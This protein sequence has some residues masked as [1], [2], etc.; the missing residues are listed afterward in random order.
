MHQMK[1]SSIAFDVPIREELIAAELE[2]NRVPLPKMTPEEHIRDALAHP[3]GTG[4]LDTVVEAGETV[5]VVIP[6]TTRK[7]Q[8][9]AIYVPILVEELNACGVRDED[10]LI[11]SA[12]G[13]H[14]R[15]TRE[16]WA[17]LVGEEILG[18]VRCEDHVCTDDANLK[19]MGVTS[20]GTPVWLNA[21]AMA[22]DKLI[23][24]GGA[25]YHFLA[26]YGGGRK[27]VLPGIAGRETI[28]KNHNLALNEGFGSGSNPMVRSANLTG[29]NPFHA[30]MAEAAELAKPCFLLNVVADGDFNIIRAFAGDYIEAHAAACKLVDD[31]DGVYVEERTPLVIAS[32]GGYP[33]DIN[34]YQTSKTL[35]NA[36]AVVADG[37]T[38]IL[39]SECRE[40]FGDADCAR[41]I[42]GFDNMLDRERDLRENFSIGAYVGFLFCESA[43]RYRFIM[44]TDIPKEKF[45]NTKIHAVK[46][47]G[48]A[49]AL[50]K[51]LN[52]GSL[53]LRTT[54]LP[55]GANT[56][57]KFRD[58][59]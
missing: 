9:P 24:T 12:T 35:S 55:H 18:R 58:G 59:Q 54:L 31:I 20:R 32:A 34:L 13:T 45:A 38:M 51:E 30:D 25:V 17:G 3:I 23:L 26:G 21:H 44:V 40:S 41:Q 57:P 28:M 52:G 50:A 2:S 16:E 4:T 10:I 19:F 33:K 37:G 43:E 53:E 7:W 36:R 22:C 46:T 56:L 8:S 48:E 5:C 27:Y 6:D 14:R 49:L 11:V 47:L 29:S 1:Y 39:L 15:Q 42:C